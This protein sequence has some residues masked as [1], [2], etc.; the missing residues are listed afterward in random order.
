VIDANNTDH[1]PL[2]APVDIVNPSIQILSP[3]NRIYDTSSCPLNFAVNE[4]AS[5]ITYSL[6]GEE[7]ITI[8][9]NTTLVGLTN[10][11]HTITV[12]AWDEAGNVGTSEPINFTVDVPFPTTLTIT[13]SAATA[14]VIGTGLL[15][16]FKKHKH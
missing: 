2:M 11:N 6:N 12:Y 9:G 16:Y 7:N 13:A 14:A 5:Q 1:Y 15:A 8:A 3:E 4:P 10:G